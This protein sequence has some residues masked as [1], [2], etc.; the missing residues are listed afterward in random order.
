QATT[1]YIR[2]DLGRVIEKQDADGSTTY[3][4]DTHGKG[5]LASTKSPASNGQVGREF[6]YDSSG[7]MYREVWTMNGETFQVDYAFDAFGRVR[8]MTY[9]EGG[10]SARFSVR[11]TYDS[12]SGQLSKVQNNVDSSQ[13][14]WELKST[15]VD[16]QIKQEALGGGVVTS[17]YDYSDQ[18]GRVSTI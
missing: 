16:G 5:L 6:L 8:T 1:T 10:G 11:N 2:D 12:D 14:F 3:T 18:T 7:R 15:K 9:P 17:D 4:W 13:T